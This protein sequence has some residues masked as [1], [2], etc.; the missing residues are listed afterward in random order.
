ML[1][2]QVSLFPTHVAFL[3]GLSSSEVPA[4]VTSACLGPAHRLKTW[5]RLAVSHFC[6]APADLVRCWAMFLQPA[7]K[8]KSAGTY[9]QPV[10]A[11]WPGL[12][13]SSAAGGRRLQ[14]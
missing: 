2:Y 12:E 5:Q 10:G 9:L 13:S 4:A 11:N 7:C 1:D 8:H 6:R 3:M 14:T